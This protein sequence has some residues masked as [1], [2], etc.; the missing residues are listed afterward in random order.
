MCLYDDFIKLM[1]LSLNL[2]DRTEIN[3]RRQNS[4]T[5]RFYTIFI[6]KI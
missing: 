2:Q 3:A 5:H 4:G 1:H 6:Y